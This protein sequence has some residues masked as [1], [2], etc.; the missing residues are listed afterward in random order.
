MGNHR[1]G[2]QYDK[3]DHDK[4]DGR[5]FAEVIGYRSFTITVV[6]RPE[7]T[8]ITHTNAQ[9]SLTWTAIP[10]LNYELQYKDP[11][12]FALWTNL[13]TVVATEGGTAAGTDSVNFVEQRL[14]R[15]RVVP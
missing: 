13:Q 5:R 2:R 8:E 1:C 4:S 7:F 10:G 14:Y 6:S 9:V 3:C 11:D 15:V 12:A